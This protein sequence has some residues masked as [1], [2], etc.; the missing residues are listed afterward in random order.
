MVRLPFRYRDLDIP[1]PKRYVSRSCLVPLGC[2]SMY[3]QC[4]GLPSLI[5]QLVHVLNS[6]TQGFVMTQHSLHASFHWHWMH[7][8][9]VCGKLACLP[10]TGMPRQRPSITVL[11]VQDV[12]CWTMSQDELKR[13]L[14]EPGYWT[15]KQL[16]DNQSPVQRREGMCNTYL[17]TQSTY[18]RLMYTI[19]AFIA[20]GMYVMLDYQV[21]SGPPL[22]RQLFSA[23]HVCACG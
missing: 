22:H 15:N 16:P 3:P 4:G 11:V 18:D 2:S 6:S 21:R 7:R 14:M 19:Q 5:A 9:G 1:N 12:G 17:P 8:R 23:I 20:Q 10:F 13:R